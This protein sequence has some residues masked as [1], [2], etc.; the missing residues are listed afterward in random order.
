MTLLAQFR[1]PLFKANFTLLVG[2]FDDL[3]AFL[4][5]RAFGTDD[6]Q[7]RQAKTMLLERDGANEVVL[8]FRPAFDPRQPE[9]MGLLAHEALHAVHFTLR[10]RGVEDSS[11]LDEVGNYFIEWLVKAIAAQVASAAVEQL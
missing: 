1:E 11:V 10:Q 5:E 3:T 4:R 2:E 6:L 7:P 8:W 9:D